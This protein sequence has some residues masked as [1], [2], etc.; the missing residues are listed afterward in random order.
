MSWY[1]ASEDGII[2]QYAS[3]G[4]LHD[5]RIAIEAG[6]YPALQGFIDVGAT[7]NILLCIYQLGIL[8]KKARDQSVKDTAKGLAAMMRGQE[9]VW[10]TQGMTDHDGKK[11]PVKKSL[12]NPKPVSKPTVRKAKKKTAPTN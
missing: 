5:L 12:L 2:D 8:A 9:T 10:I 4:G 1:L 6:N 11:S 7:K 3:G